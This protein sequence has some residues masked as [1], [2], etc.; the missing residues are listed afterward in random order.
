MAR[1]LR[2][3]KYSCTFEPFST[4]LQTRYSKPRDILGKDIQ[5]EQGK[6]RDLCQESTKNVLNPVIIV[7]Q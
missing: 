5:W 7:K 3:R 4:C 1:Y 6:G 2:M